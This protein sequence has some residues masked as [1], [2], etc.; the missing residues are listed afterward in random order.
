MSNNK[1]KESCQG[2]INEDGDLGSAVSPYTKQDWESPI[3]M[4][5]AS[6]LR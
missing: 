3:L 6:A 4:S 2:F 1:T 5:W